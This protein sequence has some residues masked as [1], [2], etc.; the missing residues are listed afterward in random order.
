MTNETKLEWEKDALEKYTT[1]HYK[2]QTKYFLMKMEISL[3]YN[4]KRVILGFL[5][6]ILTFLY[7]K[8]FKFSL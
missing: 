8:N 5:G 3:S 4:E 2:K 1:N 7:I 6:L